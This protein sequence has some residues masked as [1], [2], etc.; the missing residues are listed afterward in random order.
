[1]IDS[2]L[3]LKSLL[4]QSERTIRLVFPPQAPAPPD[5]LYASIQETIDLY[6]LPVTCTSCTVCIHDSLALREWR[7]IG[8]PE[9][10]YRRLKVLVGI[11]QVGNVGYVERKEILLTPGLPPVLDHRSTELPPRLTIDSPELPRPDRYATNLPITTVF[12]SDIHKARVVR[13][14]ER[15]WERYQKMEIRRRERARLLGAWL[16]DARWFIAHGSEDPLVRYLTDSVDLIL[17]QI[18]KR[19]ESKG[20]EARAQE[21]IR[22]QQQELEK[23]V[24]DIRDLF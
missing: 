8:L 4:I 6:R 14:E 5:D 19:Y 9:D 24:K 23:K 17:D 15:R 12:K 1:M 20:A 13:I 3:E 18:V 2:P 11:E 16:D 10:K 22:R 7:L 21:E